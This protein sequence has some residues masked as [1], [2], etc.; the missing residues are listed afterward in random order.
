MD[1]FTIIIIEEIE[2]M[3]MTEK[4]RFD[5]WEQTKQL[6][7]AKGY[8][9]DVIVT[10]LLADTHLYRLTERKATISVKPLYVC[11]MMSQEK[12]KI[13]ECLQEVIGV[14]DFVVDIVFE[15]DL[16]KLQK[17]DSQNKPKAEQDNLIKEFRFDNFIEGPSNFESYKAALTCAMM[18]ATFPYSPLYIYGNS[19]LGKTHLLH[20][21]GNYIKEHHPEMRIL[22]LT[23]DDFISRVVQ[24]SHNNTLK[25]LKENMSQLDVLL[26]DDI[27]F[28]SGDKV[29]STETLFNIYNQLQKKKKLMVITSDKKP[30]EIRDLEDRLIS[31]LSNGLTY[32]I[33]APEF[34]TSLKILKMKL[35]ARTVDNLT[36]DEDV[37]AYIATYY[38]QDVRRLEGALNRLI[39]YS[40]QFSENQEI[41]YKLA[42]EAFKDDANLLDKGEITLAKIKKT[43]AEYYNISKAKLTGKE[44]TKQI[45]DARHIAIY[46]CR[47][48]LDL[49]FTKI[50]DEFGRRDHSTI[51]SAC[52]KIEQRLENDIPLKMAIA[53]IEKILLQ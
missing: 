23:S 30:W 21:I 6:L 49:P 52:R 51:M 2:A 20:A 25:D 11:A 14:S 34:E 40:I 9:D 15:E 50:G 18:P 3:S 7:V 45:T 37:L 1:C 26:L 22:Y 38:S 13:E 53:E 48:H 19:G 8:F 29:K 12:A 31:R 28:L 39:F 43:V 33:E 27:Q 24:A 4:E 44:K 46:L 10:T 32:S 41:S 35:K 42:L 36:I 17:E 5:I 47:K 16:L